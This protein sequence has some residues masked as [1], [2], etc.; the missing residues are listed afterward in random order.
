MTIDKGDE[1]NKLDVATVNALAEGLLELQEGDSPADVVILAS[2]GDDFSLGR[3]AAVHDPPTPNK[4]VA[5]F[6]RLQR[7]NELVQRY[8]AVTIAK[9]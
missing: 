8:P 6:S 5:E 4:L 7:L 2:A 9:V 1:G 3:Q